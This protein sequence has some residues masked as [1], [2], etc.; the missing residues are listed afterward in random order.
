VLDCASGGTACGKGLT[1][2]PAAG[3][4][5]TNG[6]KAGNLDAW[7]VGFTPQLSTAVWY[8]NHDRKKPVTHNGGQLFGGDLPAAAW[9]EMMN[10]ALSGAPVI[11]FPPPAHVGSK[12]GNATPTP[13]SSA[14][15][16]SSPTPTPSVTKSV[17]PTTPPPILPTGS[18]SSSPTPSPSQQQAGGGGQPSASPKPG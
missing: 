7:F 6:Q 11:S 5:G 8:G 13:T 12:Q 16:S 3:K 2:R 15:P 1:G 14:T 10:A 9:Q 18:P 17:L 4:T